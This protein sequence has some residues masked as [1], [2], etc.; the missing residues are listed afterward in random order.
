MKYFDEL[1][2]G[3]AFTTQ[4]RTVTETDVVMFASMTGDCNSIHVDAEVGAASAFGGRLAHGL[5]VLSMAHGLMFFTG[6]LNE[7]NGIAFA[8]IE[9][10][11]FL[12]PVKIGDTIKACVTIAELRP[13]RSK[14][15]RGLT[16]FRFEVLNQRGEVVLSCVK[17]IMMRKSPAKE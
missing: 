16:S 7:K 3:D 4:G 14:P 11:Q 13:S 9:D 1:N 17:K 8:G 12:A 5:L 15:D 2:V 10:L 6:I